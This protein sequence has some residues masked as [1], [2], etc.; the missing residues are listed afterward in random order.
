MSINIQTATGLKVLADKTTKETIKAALGYTPADEASLN[1]PN[2]TDDESGDFYIA[3]EQGNIIFKVD[4]NGAHTTAVN[5]LDGIYS[6]KDTFYITD[7]AGNIVAK[8][9]ENGI[10]TIDLFINNKKVLTEDALEELQAQLDNLVNRTCTYE[11]FP[12]I[13]ISY[14]KLCELAE[15]ALLVPGQQYRIVDYMTTTSQSNTCSAEH[16]FDIIVTA[17]SSNTLSENARAIKAAVQG[18]WKS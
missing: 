8:I 5:V 12:M 14:S 6:E 11:Y 7:E 9:D 16:P 2:I 3:D 13:N 1:L 15:E 17:N 4:E 18:T 10:H